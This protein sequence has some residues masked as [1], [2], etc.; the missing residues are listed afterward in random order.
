MALAVPLVE[1]TS[2]A[3]AQAPPPSAAV[4]AAAKRALAAVDSRAAIA[5]GSDWMASTLFFGVMR[6]HAV[7]KDPEAL[8]LATA[9]AEANKYRIDGDGDGVRAKLRGHDP[10]AAPC[11][12]PPLPACAG[13]DSCRVFERDVSYNG[14]YSHGRCE[15]HTDAA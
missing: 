3:A 13:D 6:Y 15:R 1:V 4:L 2:A 8:Q 11:G 7:S 12:D 5:S 10:A 9:W 14:G